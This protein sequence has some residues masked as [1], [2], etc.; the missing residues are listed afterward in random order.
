MKQL[1]KITQSEDGQLV[2]ARDLH[3]FLEYGTPFTTWIKRQLEYGFSEGVDYQAYN[4]FVSASNG[5]GG[6]VKTDYMLTLDC[7]KHI[8][9][10]QRN[11]KGFE[12]R[13]YF[14]E[15]E[16]KARELVK[17]MSTL[18]LLEATIKSMR[19]QRVELDEIR[20]DL[21]ELK[22]ITK[23]RPDYFTIVGFATLNGM[24]V[25][26]KLAQRLGASAA[27]MCKDQGIQTESIPDP[28]FGLVRMYPKFILEE[29][30]N[31]PNI[32]N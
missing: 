16:K 2:S 28:R 30:F 20:Q 19:E 14:I 12:A 24:A 3:E 29:V 25:G 6:S 15:I 10:L 31:Q 5:V 11:E 18:D 17:P 22:A 8:A 23:T 4:N 26:L 13:K 21:H 1:I 9:M 32:L 27:K 7:A